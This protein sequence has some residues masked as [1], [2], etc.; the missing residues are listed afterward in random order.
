MS[1]EKTAYGL[2]D[3]SKAFSGLDP[4]SQAALLGTGG[5]AVGAGIGGLNEMRKSK[6]RRRTSNLAPWAMG[7]GL[8]GAS[9]PLLANYTPA[10][11]QEA[12]G[13]VDRSSVTDPNFIEERVPGTPPAVAADLAQSNKP[14]LNDIGA[15]TP[16]APA[17][18]A[19]WA[20]QGADFAFRNLIDTGELTG[21]N[22]SENLK[23]IGLTAAPLTTAVVGGAG[24]K[25]YDGYRSISPLKPKRLQKQLHGLADKVEMSEHRTNPAVKAQVDNA[26]AALNRSLVKNPTTNAPYTPLKPNQ[27]VDAFR[28][29]ADNLA[30]AKKV[31]TT[32]VGFKPSTG[33]GSPTIGMAKTKTL[34]GLDRALHTPLARKALRRAGGL[35]LLGTVGAMPFKK[36]VAEPIA[37]AMYP[38]EPFKA[39]AM[40]NI[41]NAPAT[42]A[43]QV[44]GVA[45]APPQIAPP[46]APVAPGVLKP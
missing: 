33:Q 29:L 42:P 11:A 21:P 12:P 45:K 37:S 3:L 9:L 5:A 20:A 17:N 35:G 28:T 24:A 4:M 2:G 6:E 40:P 14:P 18:E 25:A 13:T 16:K 38:Q 46:P 36:Y 39:P 43:A 44:P 1:L 15:G 10:V 26:T 22:P 27:R 32:G 23:N 31:P 8:L 30:A 34:T 41:P 19:P 7:A